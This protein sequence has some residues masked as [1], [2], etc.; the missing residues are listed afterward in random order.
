VV[1]HLLGMPVDMDPIMELARQHTL[2]VVEDCA[3]APGATYKGK[4][5]VPS[6]IMVA[7]A[8]RAPRT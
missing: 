1:V 2:K 8:S 6:A 7:T 4:K 5:V 3:Q